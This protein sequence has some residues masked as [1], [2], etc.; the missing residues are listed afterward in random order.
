[1]E[2]C[3]SYEQ[4]FKVRQNCI[5]SYAAMCLVHW[6]LGIGDRHLQNALLSLETG[7][8]IGIDFGRAFETTNTDQPIPEMIP[9]RCSPNFQN[10][11]MPYGYKGNY[12]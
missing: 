11:M 2:R 7:K 1:M 12:H 5:R 9:F 4:F 6:L 3:K 10:L 8:V